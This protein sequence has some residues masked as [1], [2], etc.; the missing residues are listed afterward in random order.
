MPG[1]AIIND[2]INS[3]NKGNKAPFTCPY[4]CIITCDFKNS[5]YCIA[6]A[7][8]NAKKGYFKNGFVFAGVNAY[9]ATEINSVADVCSTLMQEFSQ[10]A[11]D[12]M[13]NVN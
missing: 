12:N 9:R 2:F 6:A 5:P 1:R 11:Y 3:V 7:L 8:L 4:H 13:K 10:S